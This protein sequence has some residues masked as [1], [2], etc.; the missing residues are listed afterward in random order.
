MLKQTH[1]TVVLIFSPGG[2]GGRDTMKPP[3]WEALGLN[4]TPELHGDVVLSLF[5]VSPS[6][7]S[8]SQNKMKDKNLGQGDCLVALLMVISRTS[9]L[10]GDLPRENETEGKKP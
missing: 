3:I 4:T 7:L 10:W 8:F 2:W 9:Q 1:K 6:L 5:S